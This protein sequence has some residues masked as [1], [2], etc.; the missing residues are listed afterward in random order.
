M[1]RNTHGTRDRLV[2]ACA[3]ALVLWGGLTLRGCGFAGGV[4]WTPTDSPDS[5]PESRK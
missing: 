2:L 3:T 1:R 4:R 5:A